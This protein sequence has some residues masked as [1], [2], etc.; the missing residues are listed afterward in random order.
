MNGTRKYDRDILSLNLL[1]S[2]ENT[3][4]DMSLL[5]ECVNLLF[6]GEVPF[7]AYASS[8]NRRFNCNKLPTTVLRT[9]KL[10][11]GRSKC[12]TAPER[13]TFFTLQV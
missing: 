1:H 4:F 12:L 2:S 5:V 6:L 7:S 8:Y 3:A 10:R 9:Q 13:G 11:K